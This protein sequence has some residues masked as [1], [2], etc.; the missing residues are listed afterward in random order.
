MKPGLVAFCFPGQGSL[1]VGMGR[2]VAQA[3]PEAMEVFELGSIASGLDL[4]RLCFEGSEQELVE[5]EVQQPA[6]VATSLAVL[7]GIRERGIK[8]DFVVGHSVGEFAALAAAGALKVE[9]A[10]GLVRERGLAMAEAART[11]PG[12]M[13]A[14]LGLDD[15]VVERICRRILNVWPANYNCPGQ[16]VVSGENPAVDEACLAAEEEGAR[17]AIKLRVSGAFHSPL[18]ARAA[19]RLRPA[20]ERAKFSEPTAPFMSTVTARIESA[21]RMAPLLV[22]QLTAPVRFTQAAQELIRQGAHTFVEVGPGNVLAGLVKRIDR[23]VKT[24]SV[25]TPE[26]IDKLEETLASA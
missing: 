1:E 23:N 4:Q 13:A 16:I 6:L 20:L 2:E 10:V 18:V 26:E 24:V 5:T 3:V 9:E 7:A 11:N 15:E 25:A 14:I 19:D 8:P 12:S 22:E 17:R 21:R